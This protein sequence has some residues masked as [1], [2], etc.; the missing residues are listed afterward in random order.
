MLTHVR[1]GGDTWGL[2]M[3]PNNLAPLSHTYPRGTCKFSCDSDAPAVFLRR[4]HRPGAPDRLPLYLST[5]EG[6]PVDLSTCF[7]LFRTYVH[8]E[9]RLGQVCHILGPG[10]DAA[11]LS[12]YRSRILLSV[13]ACPGRGSHLGRTHSTYQPCTTLTHIC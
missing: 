10:C 7:G 2:H 12:T 3:A 4:N 9:P 11:G 5:Y 1:E 8:G 6:S 13:I